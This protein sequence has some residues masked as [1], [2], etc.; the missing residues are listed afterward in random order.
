MN[1]RNRRKLGACL[2]LFLFAFFA[3]F[4]LTASAD[5]PLDEI[6]TYTITVNM[7][8]DG[9][10]DMLYHIDWKVLDDSSEG[11]LT[12]VKIGIPNEHVDNVTALS[13]N[14]SKAEYYSDGGDY[15]RV[16][17]KS[18][19]YKGE[20]VSFDFSIHQS[21]MYTLDSGTNEINYAF[22]PG[23]FDEV[24]VKSLTVRWNKDK[25]KSSD[26]P[27][28][29][30]ASDETGTYLVWNTSLS[31]GESYTVNVVYPAGTFLTSDDQQYEE[32]DSDGDGAAVALLVLFPFLILVIIAVARN[33]K[34]RYGYRGGFGTTGYIGH[35]GFHGGGCA[36]ASSCA[37]ACACACAGGGRAGCSAKNFY[38]AKVAADELKQ[39]LDK[40]AADKNTKKK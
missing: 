8:N 34:G 2:T 27:A 30:E 16:D 19:H 31:E 5:D 22:T 6:E 18:S 40:F 24:E 29:S 9:T 4:S 38:G 12:W 17:F 28:G 14:I 33:R 1:N 10:M 37:C 3:L 23:W 35:G 39:K 13:D 15:V 36:C 7:E 25:V 32:G 26:A 11:P 20:I 21:Y